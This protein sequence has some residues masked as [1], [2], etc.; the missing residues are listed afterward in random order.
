MAWT[1]NDIPDQTGRVAVVTGANSGL[2][3]ETSRELARKGATVVMAARNVEK[4]DAARDEILGDI[5]DASLDLRQLDLA[6]LDSVREF[7]TKVLGDY[8]RVDL[9]INNA[10]VMG[11]PERATADGFEMQL[12][13]NHLGHFVLTALLMPALLRAEAARVVTVTSTARHL[14]RPVD[15]DDPHLRTKYEPWKSYG[16]SKL[17]NLHFA[18]ELERQLDESGAT[19]E[20]LVAH[21]GFSNTNLQAHSASQSEGR[22]QQFFHNAVERFGMHALDG[23][24]PQL[25]AATDPDADG[26]E[27]YAPRW[28]NFGV[29]VKRPLV[30]RSRNQKSM[31]TLWQISERETGVEFDVAAMVAEAKAQ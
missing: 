31:T 8:D 16:Q 19:V 17:A 2:G 28:V 7:T 3:L 27:L 11:I 21:P 4:G 5:P 12:G 30:G 10:G 9:L 26:G 22:S 15:P 1:A 25:R 23:A 24:L 14:G 13:T 18:L 29:P 6:S 20:S